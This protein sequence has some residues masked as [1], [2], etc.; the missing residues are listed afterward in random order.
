[1][2]PQVMRLKAY[3]PPEPSAFALACGK[4]GVN[5]AL[6]VTSQSAARAYQ[7]PAGR[8]LTAQQRS[9]HRLLRCDDRHSSR[10][11]WHTGR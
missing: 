3:S 8:I 2:F 10:S 5:G 4:A 1:M 11:N 6:T 9:T 7:A